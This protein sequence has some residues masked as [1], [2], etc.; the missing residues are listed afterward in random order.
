M[1]RYGACR[2][3]CARELQGWCHYCCMARSQRSYLSKILSKSLS[4]EAMSTQDI[5]PRA[6]YP[7]L[8]IENNTGHNK[9]VT[10]H[11]QLLGCNTNLSPEPYSAANYHPPLKMVPRWRRWHGTS[12]PLTRRRG[13]RRHLH[14]RSR[15]PVRPCLAVKGF[16]R[17]A[18]CSSSLSEGM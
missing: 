17:S 4:S 15:S 3:P 2:S 7:C 8:V 18:H 6:V 12:R 11:D 5:R 10:S 16:G 9:L 14:R 1:G 13:R